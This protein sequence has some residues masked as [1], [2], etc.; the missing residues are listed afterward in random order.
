MVCL[1]EKVLFGIFALCSSLCQIAIDDRFEYSFKHWITP[2]MCVLH[3]LLGSICCPFWPLL[4]EN[5]S[6]KVNE[7]RLVLASKEPFIYYVIADRGGG[8]S[9]I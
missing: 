4:G 3:L 9:P 2:I 1:Q 6:N 7:K 8:V 5:Y